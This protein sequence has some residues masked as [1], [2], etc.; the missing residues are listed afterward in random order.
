[1]PGFRTEM[2]ERRQSIQNYCLNCDPQIRCALSRAKWFKEIFN[3]RTVGRNAT[4]FRQGE[5]AGKICVVRNGWLRAI[6]LMPNGKSVTD[7]LGPGSLLGVESAAASSNCP[8]TA[9]AIEEC[10][11]EEADSAEFLRRLK[12]DPFV[13]ADVLRYVSRSMDRLRKLFYST[14][15]KVPASE[16]LIET[17]IEISQNCSTALDDD[18]V[19]INIPLS[20][21]VLADRIGCTRQWVSKMLSEFEDRGS[22]RRSGT[23][24]AFSR[25]Q[26]KQHHSQE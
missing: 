8:F 10:E 24:I 1:M 7:L 21:Q 11:I 13:A 23:W 25:Q 26:L 5:P 6:H 2:A 17:L 4:L 22:L 18:N 19:R 3:Y 9:V 16:R 15:S 20:A 14:A 12:D